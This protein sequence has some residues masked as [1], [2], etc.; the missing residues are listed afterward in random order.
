MEEKSEAEN[1]KSN[2]F[3]LIPF[4]II[5]PLTNIKLHNDILLVDCMNYHSSLEMRTFAHSC[6]RFNPMDWW[7]THFRRFV[8]SVLLR[9]FWDVLSAPNRSSSL[10]LLKA[11]WD[12]LDK[13][14]KSS[15]PLFGVLLLHG[16]FCSLRLRRFHE[17]IVSSVNS[18]S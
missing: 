4:Q 11:I 15:S 9:W 8:P 17:T 12:H 1:L 18:G 14:V 10:V 13:A 7:W 6:C 2:N 3:F 16:I 5:K